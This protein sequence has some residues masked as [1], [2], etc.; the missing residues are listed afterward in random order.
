MTDKCP[1]CGAEMVIENAVLQISF[2][3]TIS[4]KAGHV[5]NG[6]YCQGRQLEQ[7]R[8]RI[9]AM[10]TSRQVWHRLEGTGHLRAYPRVA[11]SACH[12]GTDFNAV[13]EFRQLEA[14]N[15][16]FQ[17]RIEE[18]EKPYP[19]NKGKTHWEGCWR[20]KGHH[21]CAVDEIERLKKFIEETDLVEVENIQLRAKLHE[22]GNA[23][24]MSEVRRLKAQLD[25]KE[26]TDE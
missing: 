11:C 3:Q 18:L 17:K 1:K 23:H 16:R 6:S 26:N 7:T 4:G 2:D 19:D 21:N 10:Q 12:D 20:D 5:I 13:M 25:V 14:A 22:L 24:S 8:K 9:I 15:A